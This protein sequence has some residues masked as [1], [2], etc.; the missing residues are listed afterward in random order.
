MLLGRYI[1]RENNSSSISATFD[2]EQTDLTYKALEA[3]YS[4]GSPERLEAVINRSITR[5][6][7]SRHESEVQ[8]YPTFEYKYHRPMTACVFSSV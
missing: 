2:K 6:D 1:K 5:S 7:G 8:F 4:D 3:L